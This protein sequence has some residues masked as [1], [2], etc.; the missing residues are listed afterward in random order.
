MSPSKGGDHLCAPV[1]EV[2]VFF[3]FSFSLSFSFF[4]FLIWEREPCVSIESLWRCITESHRK[5]SM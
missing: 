2:V 5:C 3:L 4:F 1:K